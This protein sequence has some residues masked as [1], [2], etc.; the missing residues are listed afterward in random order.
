MIDA[1]IVRAHWHSAG[2]KGGTGHRTQTRRLERHD[3]C[4]G[5]PNGF[6]YH[7]NLDLAAYLSQVAI[8]DGK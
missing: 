5:R 2:N 6:H 8:Q 4:A 7:A 3:G 1:A